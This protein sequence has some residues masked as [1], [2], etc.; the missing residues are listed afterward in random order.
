MIRKLLAIQHKRQNFLLF[1]ETIP[2]NAASNFEVNY[3]D[4]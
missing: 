2:L 1:H 3:V 4:K